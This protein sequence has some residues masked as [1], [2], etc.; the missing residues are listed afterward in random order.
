MVTSR[1]RPVPIAF[2]LPDPRGGLITLAVLL[3]SAFVHDAIALAEHDDA[4]LPV[5][6]L[7]FGDVGEAHDGEDSAC[8]ELPRGS[9]GPSFTLFFW[10]SSV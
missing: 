9:L 2:W 1:L 4:G 5:L 10:L 6:G 3:N 8:M 7:M